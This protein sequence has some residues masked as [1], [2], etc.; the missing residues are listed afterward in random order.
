[1]RPKGD[2]NFGIIDFDFVK[3]GTETESITSDSDFCSKIILYKILTTTSYNLFIFFF[4]YP[5]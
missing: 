5:L 2:Q 3:I 1:M 4:I